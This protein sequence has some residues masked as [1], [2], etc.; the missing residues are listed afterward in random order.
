MMVRVNDS[1]KAVA[2]AFA[3]DKQRKAE[4]LRHK[5]ALHDEARAKLRSDLDTNAAAGARIYTYKPVIDA[6]PQCPR[7]WIL[8]GRHE[9]IIE[10]ENGGENDLFKCR[11]CGYEVPALSPQ[12]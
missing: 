7:C 1:L 12:P 6:V 11:E 3:F 10:Q 8:R 2:E 9:P 5:L 4:E